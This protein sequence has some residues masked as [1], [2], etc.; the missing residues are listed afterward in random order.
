MLTAADLRVRFRDAEDSQALLIRVSN[1]R[2]S[3]F[4]EFLTIAIGNESHSGEFWIL[5]SNHPELLP[6]FGAVSLTSR[7]MV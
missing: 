2:C 3:S 5:H 6:T 4:P 7:V 1:F